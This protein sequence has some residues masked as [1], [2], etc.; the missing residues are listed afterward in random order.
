MKK[1]ATISLVTGRPSFH[2]SARTAL[3]AKAK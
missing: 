3:R 2:D 1:P